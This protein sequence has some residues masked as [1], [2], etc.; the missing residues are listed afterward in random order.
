MEPRQQSQLMPRRTL[1]ME[2][3]DSGAVVVRSA[4]RG[5]LVQNKVTQRA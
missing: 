1:H 5:R 3:R 2:Q 4:V